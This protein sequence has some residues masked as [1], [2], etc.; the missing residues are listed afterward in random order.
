MDATKIGGS[1]VDD[2]KIAP[3]HFAWETTNICIV[4]RQWHVRSILGLVVSLLAV[5]TICA[6]YEGLRQA[7]RRFKTSTHRTAENVGGKRLDALLGLDRITDRSPIFA[8]RTE[9]C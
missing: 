2:Q 8:I 7:I 9:P 4:V 3:V 5:T 6:G 1:G